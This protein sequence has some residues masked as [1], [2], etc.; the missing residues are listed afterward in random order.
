MCVGALWLTLPWPAFNFLSRDDWPLCSC[1]EV[2]TQQKL[3][4]RAPRQTRQREAER[5]PPGRREVRGAASTASV[6]VHSD[7]DGNEKLNG[8]HIGSLRAQSTVIKYQSIRSSNLRIPTLSVASHHCIVL[9][10]LVVLIAVL[11]CATHLPHGGCTGCDPL[12]VLEVRFAQTRACTHPC[13]PEF[14]H[15]ATLPCV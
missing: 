10:I 11:R 8:V 2:R 14:E 1:Q 12:L 5:L 13:H 6:A 9:C 7:G 15:K 3:G 4:C